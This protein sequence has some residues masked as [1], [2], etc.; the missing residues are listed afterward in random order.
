MG[1]GSRRMARVCARRMRVRRMLLLLLLLLRVRVRLCMRRDGLGS[2]AGLHERGERMRRRSR[3]RGGRRRFIS[4]RLNLPLPL[5]LLMLL[6]L[7]LLLLL[8]LMLMLLLLLLLGH[9]LGRRE[10]ALANPSRVSDPAVLPSRRRLLLS[11]RRRLSPIQR[12]HERATPR[13]RQPVTRAQR[14]S[15]G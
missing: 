14:L 9:R 3:R 13:A 4:A 10:Q 15:Q 12:V 7:L 8:L 6:M 1:G 5:L 11:R 2:T